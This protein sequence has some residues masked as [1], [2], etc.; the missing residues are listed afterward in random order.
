MD[1]IMNFFSYHLNNF[2]M[3][4]SLVLADIVYHFDIADY[5]YH[6][7]NVYLY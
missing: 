3:L 2:C 6:V 5:V 1:C 4:F 7:D